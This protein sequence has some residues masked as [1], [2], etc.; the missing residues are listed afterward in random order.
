MHQMKLTKSVLQFISGLW[1]ETEA[2][3]RLSYQDCSILPLHG[4]RFDSGFCLGDYSYE[5]SEKT[6]LGKLVYQFKYRANQETGQVLANLVSELV[7]DKFAS[8]E[9]LVSVPPSF[10]PRIFQPADFLAEKVSLKTGLTWEKYI[11]YRTRLSKSQKDIRNKSEKRRNIAGM[12]KL[13]DAEP[14]RGKKVLLLD[15]IYDTGASI[16]EICSVLKQGGAYNIGVVTLAKTGFD[17][18]GLP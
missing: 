13:K 6:V 1:R 16:A 8:A 10:T 2:L 17:Q 11:L 4:S 14:I 12:F 3:P 5:N 7:K 15:D 18:Y 9:V